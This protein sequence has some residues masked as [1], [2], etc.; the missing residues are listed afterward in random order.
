[1]Y[2]CTALDQERICAF[3]GHLNSTFYV[4]TALNPDDMYLL[5]GSGDNDAYIRKVSDPAAPPF[6]LKGHTGEVTNLGVH[7]IRERCVERSVMEIKGS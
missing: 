1:M 4:K 3:S 2:S 5:S 6:L 7:R